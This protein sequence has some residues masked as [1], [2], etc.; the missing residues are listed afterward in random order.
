MALRYPTQDLQS[1]ALTATGAQAITVD[2]D[3]VIDGVTTQATGNRTLDLTFSD[4]LPA[5]TRLLVKSKTSGTQETIFGT[6]IT[7]STITGVAGKTFT[8]E[9]VF[10][11]VGFV[12]AG[13]SVQID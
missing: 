7:A 12:P 1:I 5:G 11:G 4:N 6:G 9:F 13:A 10:D 2:K 8:Q 3:A